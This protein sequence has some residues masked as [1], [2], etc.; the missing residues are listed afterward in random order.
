MRRIGYFSFEKQKFKD[1]L[2]GLYWTNG[3]NNKAESVGEE[4]RA[5]LLRASAL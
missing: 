3:M 1:A 2:V 5:G 4:D